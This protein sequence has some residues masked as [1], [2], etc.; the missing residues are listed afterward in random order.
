MIASPVFCRRKV[1][2]TALL[3]PLA[4]GIFP[5]V[6]FAQDFERFKAALDASRSIADTLAANVAEASFPINAQ[7]A[8]AWQDTDF[9]GRRQ[10]AD[11]AVEIPAEKLRPFVIEGQE[12]LYDAMLLAGVAPIPSPDQ[13][14][15]IPIEQ[16]PSKTTCPAAARTAWEI[17]LDA[18]GLL[19][20]SEIIE[21]VLKA[22]GGEQSMDDMADAVKKKDIERFFDGCKKLLTLFGEKTFLEMFI[23]K[24]GKKAFSKLLA[25]LS[26]RMIPFVGWGYVLVSIALSV[27][28]HW[29]DIICERAE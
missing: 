2:G 18:L 28:R 21:E 11:A 12:T 29:E 17:F 8:K 25:A 5:G 22:I 23:D 3:A 14:V 1:L 13:V 15:A 19:D 4:T 16:V 26:L 6:A 7:T 27:N 24:A 20:E 10:L 9:Q